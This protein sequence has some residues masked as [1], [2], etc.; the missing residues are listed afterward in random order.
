MTAN[1]APTVPRNAAWLGAAGVL[2]FIAGVAG[3]WLLDATQ[4]EFAAFILTAYG[5]MILSFMG[6]IY[7]GLVMWRGGQGS[8]HWYTI[9]VLP[10]LVGWL[11][12]MLEPAFG[13]PLLALAFAAVYVLDRAA[14]SAGIAPAWYARMRGPLSAAVVLLLILGAAAA[15]LRLP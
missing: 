3:I 4:A 2:P 14:V 15:L 13:L 5:A 11:A 7:W 12:L 9:G 10:A 6:A 1:A 8:G